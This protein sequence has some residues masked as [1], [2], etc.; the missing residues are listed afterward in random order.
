MFKY[1]QLSLLLLFLVSTFLS[2][3]SKKVE[4]RKFEDAMIELKSF[5]D[6]QYE[7]YTSENSKPQ[8]FPILFSMG[9]VLSEN[10]I[11]SIDPKHPKTSQ[12]KKEYEK[13]SKTVSSP[14]DYVSFGY[15]NYQSL[16][17]KY[18]PREIISY[19]GEREKIGKLIW[20]IGTSHNWIDCPVEPIYSELH[21][22]TLCVMNFENA[23]EYCE[24]YGGRLP[25][26]KEFEEANKIT[27]DVMKKGRWPKYWTSSLKDKLPA[28]VSIS[29]YAGTSI[30]NDSQ[31]SVR[32]VWEK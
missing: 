8:T 27:T 9:N 16:L 15:S 22:E 17:K 21:G 24:N 11:K 4:I 31:S 1:L 10:L 6:Q 25:T 12:F 32:C 7:G 19:E 20:Q 5:H 26:V 23:K 18:L 28:H 13:V 29:T 2:A 30:G 14:D 3:Q